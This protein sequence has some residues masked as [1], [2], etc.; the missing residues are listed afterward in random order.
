MRTLSLVR[1]ILAAVL[2]CVIATAQNEGAWS[3]SSGDPTDILASSVNGPC[4][5]R[6]NVNP[7]TGHVEVI[8]RNSSGE[9]V[10]ASSGNVEAGDSRDF[11]LIQGWSIEVKY[12][13]T[14]QAG[15]YSRL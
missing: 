13:G 14:D 7:G 2:S 5:Y 6:V 1:A 3:V 10:V 12:A 9:K 15:G 4:T 8:V 11:D